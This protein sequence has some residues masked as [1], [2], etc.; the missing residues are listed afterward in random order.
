M[1]ILSVVVSF[2]FLVIIALVRMAIE[3]ALH[4]TAIIFSRK[5]LDISKL[6]DKDTKYNLL[7]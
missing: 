3:I 5:K 4:K 6:H 7:R 1:R 2:Q